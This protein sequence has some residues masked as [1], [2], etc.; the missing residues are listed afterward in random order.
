MRFA[1]GFAI[2]VA[3]VGVFAIAIA[4]HAADEID[5]LWS[6]VNEKLGRAFK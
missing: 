5:R 2:I 6:G 1:V 3:M 4:A